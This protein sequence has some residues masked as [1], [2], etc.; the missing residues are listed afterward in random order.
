MAIRLNSDFV[1]AQSLR[2]NIIPRAV[3]YFTGEAIEDD[4]VR[5]GFIALFPS[6]APVG[7]VRL[8]AEGKSCYLLL[9]GR[10]LLQSLPQFS[11]FFNLIRL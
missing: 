6:N 1:A 8:F 10:H 9:G 5:A 4:E 7:V 2:E 3:L 11:H